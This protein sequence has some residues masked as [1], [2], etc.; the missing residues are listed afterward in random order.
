MATSSL[1]PS[2]CRIFDL[3]LWGEVKVGETINVIISS[4]YMPFKLV[5]IKLKRNEKERDECLSG[6]DGSCHLSGFDDSHHRSIISGNG[7]RNTCIDV[8]S[9]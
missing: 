9:C 3:H 7:R 8:Q 4:F 1:V 5:K 2:P 6:S